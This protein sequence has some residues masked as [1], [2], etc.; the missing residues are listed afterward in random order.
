MATWLI[1]TTG[2]EQLGKS[3]KYPRGPKKPP[4]KRKHDPQRPHLS[5][6]QVLPQRKK[7]KNTRAD[8]TT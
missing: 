3:R 1:E 2:R 7:D 6:A 8:T 5:V 4:L